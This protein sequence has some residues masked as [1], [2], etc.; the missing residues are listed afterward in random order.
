MNDL[1]LPYVHCMNSAGGLFHGTDDFYGNIAGLGI[2][3]YGLKPDYVNVLPNG[4]KPAL[5]WKSVVAMVKIVH[6]GESI[7]YGGTFIADR[8]MKVATIPT[9]YADGC[10]RE[11]FNKGIVKAN[12]RVTSIVGRVCMDQIM[13]DVT[14]IDVSCGDN[15]KLI[16]EH[17]SADD[18]ARDIGTIGYEIICG[19]SKRVPRI[20]M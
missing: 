13:V 3:L 18:M 15:V 11:L 12:G 14:G 1:N 2:I 16:G 4:I 5:S 9:G 20:Y 17:Y 19:V 10:R 7:G 8:E 6:P